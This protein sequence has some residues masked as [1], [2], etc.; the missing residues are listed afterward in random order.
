MIQIKLLICL[1]VLH[2]CEHSFAKKCD[3]CKLLRQCPEALN[4]VS[5]TNAAVKQRLKDALCGTTTVDGV[6][7]P[8]ICCNNFITVSVRFADTETDIETHENIALL[9]ENCGSINGDRIV[10]GSYA[11]L[12]EF[13][14]MALVSRIT[15]THNGKRQTQFHCGGTAINSRY[16]LTAAHCV[17]G[18]RLAGIRIGDFNI[19]TPE[20]CQGEYPHFVCEQHI[21]DIRINNTI[22][23]E[24]FKV[25]PSVQ[26]DIALIRLKYPI[27]F[28]F[29]N[30]KPICLPLFNKL[31]NISLDG[32]Q[33]T[34]AGWGITE[35]SRAS[36]VL[37]KVEIPIKSD[38]ECRHYYD[39]NYDSG[40]NNIINKILCAGE[41][42]KDSCKGDSG[43]PLMLEE[44]YND[45]YRMIQFGVVSYGPQQCGSATPGVYTDV[46]QYVK[47]IL[48]NIEP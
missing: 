41:V 40:T 24:D 35:F 46:R 34:V 44:L 43:G 29:K 38:N 17:V 27:D 47:W 3:S 5:D 45:I 37:R 28:S 19:N 39:R 1:L 25:L 23:H 8:M 11:N 12:Y 36:P 31:R 15:G 13:P 2:I 14:W 42:G 9:P 7:H 4:L 21:Q 20:D 10:G 22:V 6:R 33:A 30:A 18:Q 48:D 32:K 26:N 16:I